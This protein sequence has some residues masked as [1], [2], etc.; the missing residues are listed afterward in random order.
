MD[1]NRVFLFRGKEKYSNRAFNMGDKLF[2]QT[3]LDLLDD[4]EIRE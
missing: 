1:N 4:R 3:V 2:V